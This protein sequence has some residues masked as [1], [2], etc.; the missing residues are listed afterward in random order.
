MGNQMG[1]RVP[2]SVKQP[3]IDCEFG[4]RVTQATRITNAIQ[5]NAQFAAGS[6][7]I[8][9]RHSINERFINEKAERNEIS[10]SQL[11]RMLKEGKHSNVDQDLVNQI[12]RYIKL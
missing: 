11:G 2:S 8:V 6:S 7:S 1:K 10:I 9:K 12:T 3:V 5:D 4:K